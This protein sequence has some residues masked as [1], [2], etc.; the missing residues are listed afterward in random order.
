MNELRSLTFYKNAGNIEVLKAIPEATRLILDIGCGAGDNAS[1]LSKKGM[2]VDGITIS[3]VEAE[4]AKKSC[5]NVI[6]HNLE[7]GL[8]HLGDAKYDVIICSHILEHIVYPQK[9]I[10]DI[11]KIMLPDKTILLVAVPNFLVYKNR[12]KMFLG[13]FN[14]EETGLLDKTHVRWYTFKS[15]KKL[16]LDSGFNI[17][18][19][20]VEGGMPFQSYLN[21]VP[22]NKINTIK[23]LLFKISKGF[24]GGE[25][26]FSLKIKENRV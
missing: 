3:K 24:F 5:R 21:F 13:K 4:E 12:L 2:T 22:Q 18:K 17:D 7:N 16:L 19:E 14:Y 20:W 11:K 9:L 1:L 26:L 25:L 15:L 23:K 10:E 8:P 6:I